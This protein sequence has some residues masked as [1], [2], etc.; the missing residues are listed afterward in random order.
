MPPG[1]LAIAV[2]KAAKI[3]FYD[4][5]RSV[6]ILILK[7]KSEKVPWKQKSD[8]LSATIAKELKNSDT[9][10]SDIETVVSSFT[11]IKDDPTSIDHDVPD[12][13]LEV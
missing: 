4:G 12:N 10:V 2:W 7:G 6:G 3:A 5:L 9:A 1:T 8:N 11:L 13:V